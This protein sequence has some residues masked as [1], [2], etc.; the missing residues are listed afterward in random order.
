M[1]AFLFFLLSFLVVFSR[2][3]EIFAI[4]DVR[5][6]GNS[7]TSIGRKFTPVNIT[8]FEIS[9]NKIPQPV[10]KLGTVVLNAQTSACGQNHP[11][12]GRFQVCRNISARLSCFNL[13][14]D[15]NGQGKL[16]LPPAEYEILAPLTCPPGWMC[17]LSEAKAQGSNLQA[18]MVNP[19]TWNID[20]AKF[21]LKP[22]EII[23][24]KAE[25]FN[26]LLMCP[27][28]IDN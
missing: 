17:L 27:I 23:K 28:L 15:K 2:P 1:A 19:F 24:I 5:N 16:T 21:T 26:N 7:A 3:P 9:Q 8:P 4:T 10:R 6:S 11:Y 18:L 12:S 25:G 22:N 14:T 20:P 13:S